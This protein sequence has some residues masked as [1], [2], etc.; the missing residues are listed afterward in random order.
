MY[1]FNEIFIQI[2]L[3]L[4][5]SI[6]VIALTK[7]VNRPYS[8]SLVLVGLLLGLTEIPLL[9]E[10][11]QFIVQSEVF[12]V[13]I[14]SLF[15]PIL[16]G[17]ASL[18]LSFDQ[19]KKEKGPVLALALGGTL[20]SFILI[21]IGAHYLIGLSIIMSF[22]FASL[23]SATDP[24]SVISI[25]KTLGIPKKIVTI[26]EGESLFNDGVAVV[27]FQI[28]TVYLLSYI[29]MGWIGLGQGILLFLQFSLGG[30]LIGG[31]AGFI[32]SQIIR[33][34]DDFPLE[35]AFSIIMIFGSYFVAEHFH[36][37]GVIAVVVAGLIFGNYGAR[38]G[39][40]NKTKVNID[41]FFD[42]ITFFA[43]S[44]VFLMIGLEIKN[45]DLS[46]KWGY[47]ITA[48]VIVL[49]SRTIA[50]YI[51]LTFIKGFSEKYKVILN[52]GG[53]K[54]S[55]SI[56]LALSLP[57]T[58]E[59]RDDILILTFSVVLFSLLIQGLTITPII[60]KLDIKDKKEEPS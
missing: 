26:I 47:I 24:I 60:N 30:I 4:T 10:A 37:S 49:L 56:A 48:I 32:F 55:L 40:S 12:Q 36:V 5:I 34:Y 43:N 57:R 44:L 19:L 58:F 11:E 31:A 15:L 42:T 35:I 9:E 21:G 38:V 53:L 54:G 46:H 1:N 20:L 23:M 13:I 18:K 41:S 2:L 25:F 14:I 52:W 39:M 22:T 33:A 27:L 45:I 28:S 29:E 51:S 16:L 8:I 50:L 17:D 3:L 59:G 7:L 6:I